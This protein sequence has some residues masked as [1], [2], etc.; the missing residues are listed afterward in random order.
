MSHERTQTRPTVR[1]SS[2]AGFTLVELLV[3]IGIIALL[4]SILLPSLNRAREQANRI[5]C[6]SN[7]RQIAMAA[8]IYAGQDTRNNGK[9]P[10]TYFNVGNSQNSVAHTGG[11][12][13]GPTNSAYSISAP[14]T[15]VGENNVPASLY[16]LL[17]SSDLTA[18]V[19][20]CPSTNATRAYSSGGSGASIQDFS[21]WPAGK[22]ADF[23][24][25]SYN[26]PFPLDTAISGGWKFDTT[27][28]PDYPIAADM[29]PG[30]TGGSSGGFDTNDIRTT[31]FTSS[32]KDMAR[33]NSNNHGNDGQQ[34]AYVDAHVEWNATPYCGAPRSDKPFRDNIWCSIYS[35]DANGKSSD[36]NRPC[37]AQD[38]L[39]RPSDDD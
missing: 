3:V 10:R 34:V 27:L 35:V 25:Y 31:S 30:I 16:H 2:K 13:N 26:S 19:F 12:G 1:R 11:Q 32:R 15:P 5:K 23:L 22:F 24:S 4:I 21:N 28:S 18:E 36:V 14:G 33:G 8:I 9:F 17:K 6:A 20:N 29:N 38:A 37:D 39:L 7:L